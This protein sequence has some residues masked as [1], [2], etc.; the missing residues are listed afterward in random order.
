[1]ITT[2]PE[3]GLIRVNRPLARHLGIDPDWLESETGVGFMAG[4]H[5]PANADPIATVYGGHQF[6]NWVP[7]LGDAEAVFRGISRK[8]GVVYSALVPNE[9]GLD[10]AVAARYHL[11]TRTTR[12]FDRATV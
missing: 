3:P 10:R 9:K 11:R 7:Q 5:V 1:M 2:L 4:N 6:G 12:F 8:A